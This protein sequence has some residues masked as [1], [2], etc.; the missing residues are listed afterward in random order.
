MDYISFEENECITE[1]TIRKTKKC[2]PEDLKELMNDPK[3]MSAIL[4]DYREVYSLQRTED[5]LFFEANLHAHIDAWLK[6][7]KKKRIPAAHKNEDT[8]ILYM[9]GKVAT[10]FFMDRL[11]TAG[12]MINNMFL[13]NII[14]S[15]EAIDALMRYP[16][17]DEMECDSTQIL[18]NIVR[19]NTGK[20][21]P[22]KDLWYSVLRYDLPALNTPESYLSWL[23]VTIKAFGDEFMDHFNTY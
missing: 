19:N 13:P 14:D 9:V 22:G 23:S 18:Y 7:Q 3:F 21:I 16:D 1:E 4:Y 10:M 12:D 2:I 15:G 17:C 20:Y 5:E 11:R 8:E 6:R